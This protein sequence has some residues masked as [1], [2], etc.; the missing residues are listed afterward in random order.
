MSKI[1]SPLLLIALVAIGL[2][3]L[4]AGINA[5]SIPFAIQMATIVIWAAA[6]LF[7]TLK[8]FTSS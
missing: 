1:A 5:A 7:W 4:Y 3:A 8:R 6:F 2:V